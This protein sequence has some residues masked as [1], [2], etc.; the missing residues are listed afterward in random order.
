MLTAQARPT[1]TAV[2]A[3]PSDVCSESRCRSCRAPRASQAIPP[4]LLAA[5]RRSSV[6][7]PC[8]I[9]SCQPTSGGSIRCQTA[10]SPRWVRTTMNCGMCS[11]IHL[12][13]EGMIVLWYFRGRRKEEG[14]RRILLPQILPPII[15][16]RFRSHTLHTPLE[17]NPPPSAYAFLDK[18]TLPCRNHL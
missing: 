7:L 6:C 14:G 8:S 9:S 16:H 12:D 3:W 11:V 18:T 1:T 2:R 15:S 5:S 10:L 13:L 17:I 4:V